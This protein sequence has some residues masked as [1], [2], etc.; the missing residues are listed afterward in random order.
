MTLMNW[1]MFQLPLD[2]KYIYNLKVPGNV[3]ES[4]DNGKFF[5][6]AFTLTETG[7]TILI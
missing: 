4:N 5:K 6:G 7:D 3:N 1:E 2:E